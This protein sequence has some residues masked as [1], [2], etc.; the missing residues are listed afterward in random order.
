MIPKAVVD[1]RLA[2]GS[3]AFAF[4]DLGIDWEMA[5]GALQK[6]LAA[7]AADVPG[8]EAEV[9]RLRSLS[10]DAPA[11]KSAAR[12][13]Y[14]GSSLVSVAS[15]YDTDGQLLGFSLQ[16]TL[17][18]ILSLCAQSALSDINQEIWRCGYCPV[19]GGKPDFAWLDKESGA[20]W[21]VCCRCDAQWIFQR[22]QCPYCG[23]TDQRT[24]AY[25]EADEGPYRLYTCES[26][27]KYIKAIDLR[28]ADSDSLIPLERFL[29]ADLD[30]QAQAQGYQAGWLAEGKD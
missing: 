11:L 22:L 19:C 7:I 5:N 10:N 8:H 18:P 16:A 25:F 6:V 14:E 24:L 13:W 27:K 4:D 15:K 30:R 26:C 17:K 29:T 23:N 3:P 12:L 20:R 9:E 2:Q 28:R 21:L 1:E